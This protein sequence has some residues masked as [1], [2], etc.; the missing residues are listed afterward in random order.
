MSRTL[1]KSKRL[2]Q[3]DYWSS[4]AVLSLAENSENSTPTNTGDPLPR[5]HFR[6]NFVQFSPLNTDTE[7]RVD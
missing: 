7:S 5:T 2:T 6:R 4:A 3:P 1:A